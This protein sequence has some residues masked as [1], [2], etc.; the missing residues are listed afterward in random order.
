MRVRSSATRR[1]LGLLL[2][3]A[4]TAASQRRIAMDPWC[5]KLREAGGA[6][7]DWV[8]AR[9]CEEGATPQNGTGE[10]LGQIDAPPIL[11]S[12]L[13]N[14]ML[15]EPPDLPL[16]SRRL[17]KRMRDLPHLGLT[18]AFWSGIRDLS[19]FPGG[20]KRC[21][22]VSIV[23]FST[24]AWSPLEVYPLHASNESC[25]LARS[26]AVLTGSRGATRP[27]AAKGG[28]FSRGFFPSSRP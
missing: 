26:K 1:V 16:A 21:F 20:T 13:G 5:S 10:D 25:M 4:S 9:C 15:L 17:I 3:V 2:L 28:K 23:I 24:C 7:D 11:E 19:V 14:S 22:Q 18:A 6:P 12:A 27:L 8:R